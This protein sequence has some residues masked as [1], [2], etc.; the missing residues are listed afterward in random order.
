VDRAEEAVCTIK[1]VTDEDEYMIDLKRKGL[2]KIDEIRYAEERQ[3]LEGL[4]W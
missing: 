3:E 4:I 2:S 1:S